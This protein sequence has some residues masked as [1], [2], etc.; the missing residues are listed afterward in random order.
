VCQQLTDLGF[1]IRAARPKS[2]TTAD[3][4]PSEC[5]FTRT[6]YAATTTLFKHVFIYLL[7]NRTQDITQSKTQKEEG[8]RYTQE[9]T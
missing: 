4:R 5:S 3:S 7:L 8:D 9:K 6:F 2:A 1:G